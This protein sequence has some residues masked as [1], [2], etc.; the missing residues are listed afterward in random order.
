MQTSA[1]AQ[2]AS[3]PTTPAAL[4]RRAASVYTSGPPLLRR[5]QHY[6][7]WIC[8]F[9]RLVDA[10]PRDAALLDVGCGGGLFLTLLAAEGR[11][12]RGVGFDTSEAAIRLARQA[13]G[14]EAVRGTPLTFECR[15]VADGWPEGRF[16]AVSIIDVLHHVPG[17]AWRTTLEQAL[18]HLREGGTLIYKDMCR[19]PRWRAIANRLHDMV[20][21]RQWINYVPIEEVD[22]WAAARGLQPIESDRINLLWYGHD[23][24]VWTLTSQA[25]GR[26]DV[27]D[28]VER[29]ANA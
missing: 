20:L 27:A 6:R 21:A 28:A 7:P 4:A 26:E 3:L 19:R 29:H 13:A 5:L 24:R 12:S 9:D 8:P 10:T 15:S 11:I 25:K 16:D 22:A 14:A 23:L 17:D 18:E 1:S 2:T